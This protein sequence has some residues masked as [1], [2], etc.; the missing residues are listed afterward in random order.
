MENEETYKELEEIINS[1]C[2]NGLNWTN[3]QLCVQMDKVLLTFENDNRNKLK[4]ELRMT[5]YELS[6]HYLTKRGFI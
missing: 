6:R 2:E 5:I 3:Q 4:D 1:L